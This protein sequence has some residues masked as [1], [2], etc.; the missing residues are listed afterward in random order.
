MD[1]VLKVFRLPGNEALPTLSPFC[2]KLETWMRMAGVR[3]EHH[4]AMPWESPS[5]KLPFI[6]HRGERISDSDRIIAYVEEH[7]GVDLDADLAPA[8]RAHSSA[9]AAML[10]HALLF[11]IVSY[12]FTSPDNLARLRGFLGAHVPG[13]MLDDSVERYRSQMLERLEQQGIS[14][15]S[16]AERDAA[17]VRWIAAIADTLGD[18]PYLLGERPTSLDA[19]A[20]GFV[21]T[22]LRGFDQTPLEPAIASHP[23]LVAWVERIEL[24][25]W[26]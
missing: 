9:M 6:E 22:S 18:Q 5:G 3:Y 11:A 12:R 20:Y 4:V 15:W 26:S 2:L 24:G 7:W 16:D 8:D 1:D 17:A 21:A 14:D 23:N 19:I 13:P 25:W 10:E